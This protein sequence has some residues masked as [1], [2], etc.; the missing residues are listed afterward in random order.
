LAQAPKVAPAGTVLEGM[1]SSRP[2]RYTIVAGIA[3][4]QAE[5]RFDVGKALRKTSHLRESWKK[6]RLAVPIS[7]HVR[8]GREEE[9]WIVEFSLS[10]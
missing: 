7:M 4:N 1:P 5:D 8:K 9:S 3:A 2:E 6:A 10:F